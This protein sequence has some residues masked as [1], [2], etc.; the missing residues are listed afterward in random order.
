MITRYWSIQIMLDSGFSPRVMKSW[1][2]SISQVGPVT[3]LGQVFPGIRNKTRKCSHSLAVLLSWW[4][5][6]RGRSTASALIRIVCPSAGASWKSVYTYASGP[7]VSGSQE[8]RSDLWTFMAS[9]CQMT[10]GGSEAPWYKT[11][12]KFFSYQDFQG[13]QCFSP[14]YNFHR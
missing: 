3:R 8:K 6:F 14:Q 2:S 7:K 13:H 4:V 10:S 9:G 11:N 5:P 12:S 1:D